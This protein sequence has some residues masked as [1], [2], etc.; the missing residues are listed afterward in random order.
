ME[1]LSPQNEWQR[2]AL[3]LPWRWGVIFVPSVIDDDES[4]ISS[5]SGPAFLKHFH[6]LVYREQF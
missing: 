1:W 6:V 5:K 4:N 3:V 2:L